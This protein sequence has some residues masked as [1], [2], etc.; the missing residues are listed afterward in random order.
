MRL[1]TRYV[2]WRYLHTR[3]A[4]WRGRCT[5]RVPASEAAL[6]AV[7]RGS[8]T[9]SSAPAIGAS[10]YASVGHQSFWDRLCR[11][12]GLGVAAA[13]RADSPQRAALLA[14]GLL[15]SLADRTARR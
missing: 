7:A 9:G 3:V 5:R 8:N 13:H 6:W 2:I 12:A 14:V 11:W 4:H 15:R 1:Y 10:F